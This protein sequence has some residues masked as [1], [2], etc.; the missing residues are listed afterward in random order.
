MLHKII[1]SRAVFKDMADEFPHHIQLMI[2]GKDNF[3]RDLDIGGAVLQN[4]FFLLLVV[5]DE[6]LQDVHELIL[7]QHI[8]PKVSGDIVP[9]SNISRIACAAI[10]ACAIGALVE[11]QEVRVRPVQF[12]SHPNL[13]KVAYEISQ[14]AF[15]EAKNRLLGVAVV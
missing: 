6:F 13:V 14:D 9:R 12:C 5:A 10:V 2:A 15:I 4:L 7:L 11:G 8:L 3:L 1:M